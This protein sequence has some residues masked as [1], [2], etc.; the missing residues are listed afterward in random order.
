M[1]E[2]DFYRQHSP[3]TDPGRHRALIAGAV[4]SSAPS[5]IRQMC[6]L[7]QDSVCHR[8]ETKWRFG[9]DLPEQRRDEANKRYVTAIVDHIGNFDP[10]PPEQRFAG[11]CRDFCILAT[12]MLREAGVPARMRA[13]F[14]NYFFSGFNVDHW[15]V[16]VWDETRGW[17]LVDAQVAGDRGDYG[18]KIDPLDVPRDAFMVGGQAWVECRAGLYDPQDFGVVPNEIVGMWEVQGNVIRDLAS[19]NRV[20]TL[21]WDTWPLIAKHY[22]LLDDQERDLL[23]R[24][25]IVS[26]N[27]GPFE[28][29]IDLYTA[30]LR[31]QAPAALA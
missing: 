27:G 3:L 28:T 5:D 18:V 30:E 6:E 16:E 20:E 21:P 13:G 1:D 22:D 2:L 31:L 8:D 10:R 9:F 15:V 14:A 23:D 24:A 4:G 12:S 7:I 17:H 29:A 25:A 11:S 19:L 26:A